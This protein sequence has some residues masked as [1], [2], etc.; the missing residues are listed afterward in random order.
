MRIRFVGVNPV[1]G[2]T[3]R[4]N[5][6][7]LGV[8]PRPPRATQ[9]VLTVI[10]GGASA[11]AAPEAPEGDV[12]AIN[13]AWKWCRDRGVNATLFTIDP[14]FL[15]PADIAIL[16][17]SCNP[18]LARQCGQVFVQPLAGLM[19]GTTS[20]TAVPHV[21]ALA[22]YSDVRFFGCEG[23]FGAQTHTFK[24]IDGSRLTVRCGGTEFVTN[25][26]ML[27]QCEVLAEIIRTFPKV[28][29]DRSGGLLGAMITDPDPDI[30][31]ASPQIHEA[32]KNGDKND[33]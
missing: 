12:W 1:S 14:K 28:Y 19:R 10:G 21:S 18:I 11:L 29:K 3:L 13:G 17:D 5:R 25:P 24:D 33:N 15:V 20:A 2:S 27:M 23:S 31:A 7:A 22:G 6:K 8:Y 16:G 32:L 26:Q 4:R 9:P 30:I